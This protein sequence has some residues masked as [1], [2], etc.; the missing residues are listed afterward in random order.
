MF[1]TNS[2]IALL[3]TDPGNLT[4]AERRELFQRLDRLTAR[5][6]YSVIAANALIFAGQGIRYLIQSGALS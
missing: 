1:D 5:F 2:L 6:A 3:A 4:P